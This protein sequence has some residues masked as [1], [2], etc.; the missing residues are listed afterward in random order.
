MKEPSLTLSGFRS[1]LPS[2]RTSTNYPQ[3]QRLFGAP[4]SGAES[5][6]VVGT[7][8]GETGRWDG[9]RWDGY[10]INLIVYGVCWVYV[11]LFTILYPPSNIFATSWVILSRWFSEL[12]VWWDM[13]G[14]YTTHSLAE[15]FYSLGQVWYDLGGGNSNI[16]YFYPITLGKWS[17]L[18][19][20]FLR[21]VVQPP[22]SDSIRDLCT[23]PGNDNISVT[24]RHKL[25]SMIFR[26]SR[27]V[28]GP[29]FPRSLK[30][31]HLNKDFRLKVGWVYLQKLME[32]IDL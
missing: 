3:G 30:G 26:T 20:I 16:C 28:V 12:P 25:E 17:N 23:L 6:R 11:Q 19:S 1:Y 10:Q 31:S 18:T 8:W 7:T 27:L 9:L 29:M 5:R 15:V 2:N 14:R 21:W 4:R 13:F 32:L 22:T 24:S